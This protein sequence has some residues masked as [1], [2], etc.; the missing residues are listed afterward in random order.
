MK[1]AN[2]TRSYRPFYALL[3]KLQTSDREE[4]KEDIVYSVSNGRTKSLSALSDKELAEAI[5]FLSNAA[6]KSVKK[7]AATDKQRELRSVIITLLEKLGVYVINKDWSAVN[8]FLMQPRIAG[9]MLYEMD[10]AE[11]AALGR[12]L[13]AII[14]K[15]RGA[16]KVIAMGDFSLN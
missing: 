15:D 5:R 12:K 1:Q 13:R 7:P 3:A 6:G 4:L 10:E 14:D 16:R 8:T 9:K 11:L 2:N